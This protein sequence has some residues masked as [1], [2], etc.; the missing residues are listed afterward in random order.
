MNKIL[1]HDDP[2]FRSLVK[3]V[4]GKEG[5]AVYEANDGLDAL[6]TVDDDLL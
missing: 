6:L 5:F 1:V 2:H 3:V 4:L